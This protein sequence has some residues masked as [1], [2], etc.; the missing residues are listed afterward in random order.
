MELSI[1]YYEDENLARDLANHK[2]TPLFIGCTQYRGTRDSFNYLPVTIHSIEEYIHW[3]GEGGTE[4]VTVVLDESIDKKKLR[5]TPQEVFPV[6]EMHYSIKDYFENGGT[7]CQ[8]I[9]VGTCDQIISIDYYENALFNLHHLPNETVIFPGIEK[10]FNY[11]EEYISFIYDS[12]NFYGKPNGGSRFVLKGND[13]LS[14]QEVSVVYDGS[15]FKKDSVG[16]IECPL[17]KT[18]IP[19]LYNDSSVYIEHVV[20]NKSGG[21]FTG[22]TLEDIR[23]DYP[24]LYSAI[25]YRVDSLGVTIA[26]TSQEVA[27]Y[28]E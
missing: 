11:N 8:V 12:I 5:I 22:K 10:V 28:S 16:F 24:R 27:R 18:T 7:V 25:V 6:D 14:Q 4:S 20:D 17:V 13:G 23:D 19:V 2:N 15:L 1:D 21:Y 3:F 9:S 26:G